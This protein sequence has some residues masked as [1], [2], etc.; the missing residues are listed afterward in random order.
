[1]TLFPFVTQ[2]GIHYGDKKS[3]FPFSTIG[4]K[5]VGSFVGLS[6]RPHSIPMT[7]RVEFGFLVTKFNSPYLLHSSSYE[8]SRRTWVFHSPIFC[9]IPVPMISLVE[10]AACTKF[11]KR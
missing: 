7:F 8:F 9:A 10:L 1:M 6:Y 11:S 5:Y 2:G 3:S 4:I